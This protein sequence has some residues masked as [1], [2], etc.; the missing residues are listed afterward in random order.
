[1]N[2]YAVSRPL[3][4]KFGSLGD[5]VQLT[6]LIRQ[7]NARFRVPVDLVSSGAWTRP[8][9]EGQPGV[10]E[11][12]I[13]RSRRAPFWLSRDQQRVALWLLARPAG[14]VWSCDFELSRRFLARAGLPAARICDAGAFPVHPEERMVERWVRF[15][16]A[17]PAAYGSDLQDDTPRVPAASHLVVGAARVADCDAWLHRR[18]LRGRPIVAIQA[19]N[20]RTMRLGP[21]RRPSN[22]KYWPEERWG[23]VLGAVRDRRPGHAIVLLGVE[24][25]RALN[26]DIIRAAKIAD[27][28]NAAG[29][30][31]I[32]RLM[33]LLQRAESTISGDTGPAH[34]A[35][36]VGCPVIV[37]FGAADPVVNQPSATDTQVTAL[38]ATVDGSPNILGITAAQVI[39]AWLQL[40]RGTTIAAAVGEGRSQGTLTYIARRAEGPVRRRAN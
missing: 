5:V 22:T 3:V 7:L 26:D 6:A 24:R 31:P 40:S 12:H 14:P 36:A 39:D 13:V 32:P 34:V 16:C 20:K 18:G 38:T 28:C 33:A 4:M 23:A 35:A 29:D 9:L 8:L 1:M 21:R 2:S 37:L 27:V 19:G 30:L 11:I 10:G 17:T 25:E 15:G